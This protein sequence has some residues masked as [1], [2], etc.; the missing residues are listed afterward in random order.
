MQAVRQ[1]ANGF[2][3]V[4][5]AFHIRS[6]S[7]K[8]MAQRGVYGAFQCRASGVSHSEEAIRKKLPPED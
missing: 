8:A 2:N 4:R 6:C 7:M 3:A 1:A 5:P